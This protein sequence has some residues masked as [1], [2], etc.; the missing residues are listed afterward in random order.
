MLTATSLTGNSDTATALETARNIGGVSFNGIDIDL[1]NINTGG[2]QDTS[3]TATQ[4][5]TY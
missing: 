3:G 4:A 2:N 5:D 1:H